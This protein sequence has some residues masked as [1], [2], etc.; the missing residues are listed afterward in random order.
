MNLKLTKQERLHGKKNINS[1]FV[2]GESF[3]IYPF[4]VVVLKQP[5]P[6]AVPLRL[7]VSISRRL[8]KRAVDRNR[9]KR[10]VR[11]SWRKRK[12]TLIQQLTESG[13]SCDVA[14]IF[15]AKTI[16]AYAEVETKIML[17]LQRLTSLNAHTVIHSSPSTDPVD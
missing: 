1:L 11:E 15:T 16:P 2:E 8:Y 13:N 17:I 10:L 3:F 12:G 9:I 6:S 4:K 7:L 5:Q 14:L